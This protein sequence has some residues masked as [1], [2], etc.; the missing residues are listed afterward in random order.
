MARNSPKI[1]VGLM[2]IAMAVR[3]AAADNPHEEGG[4]AITPI[5]GTDFA[6]DVSGGL[7][8]ESPPRIRFTVTAGWLPSGYVDVINRVLVGR[9]VYNQQVADVV[10]TTIENSF[11]GRAG[12]SFRPAPTHG[13]FF[14]GSYI[15]QSFGGEHTLGDKI[16]LATGVAVPDVSVLSRSFSLNARIHMVEASLGW[17]WYIGSHVMISAAVSAMKAVGA[18]VTIDPQFTPS[19]PDLTRTFVDAAAQRLS[20]AD[21]KIYAPIGS[22]FLGYTF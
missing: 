8:I 7:Q 10:K 1:V 3:G 14:G 22:L 6:L 19:R 20:T 21:R 17:E 11:I 2:G 4:W 12:L 15:L 13:F 9:G 16:E 5:V 18:N